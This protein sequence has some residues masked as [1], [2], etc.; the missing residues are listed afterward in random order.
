MEIVRPISLDRCTLKT[1]TKPM[2][3]MIAPVGDRIIDKNQKTIQS[4]FILQ[5]VVGSHEVIHEVNSKISF[6]FG[7][8]I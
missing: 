1:T 7:T 5:S 4:R 2:T 3:K 6:G 8:Y